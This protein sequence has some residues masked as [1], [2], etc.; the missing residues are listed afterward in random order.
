M[1]ERITTSNRN[2]ARAG[3][4]AIVSIL[5]AALGMV[6]AAYSQLHGTADFPRTRV[7]PQ[8]YSQASFQQDGSQWVR[9]HFGSSLKRPFW[10]PLVTPNGHRVTRM[11]NPQAPQGE[12]HHYSV[13]LAHQNVAGTSFWEDDG[14]SK[15]VHVSIDRFVDKT[16]CAAMTSDNEWRDGDGRVLL[17]ER[18]TT[19]VRPIDESS[20]LMQI[21]VEYLP[22]TG[23]R[24]VILGKTAYGL[25]GVR[26]TKTMDLVHG[27]GR[28]LDSEGRR[29]EA[30]IFRKPARWVDF[31][32][33]VAEDAVAG[34]ALFDH[35]D[36]PTFPT[37]FHVRDVG[38]MMPSLTLNESIEITTD[39]PLKLRYGLWVHDGLGETEAIEAAWKRFT[40]PTED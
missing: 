13:W 18:R 16:G 12:R 28:I 36:N 33:R 26:V 10:Y 22:A 27:R 34:I 2:A 6:N 29:N 37:P 7:V 21:D 35:P 40:Q 4:Q 30:R 24:S 19:T 5:L 25:L 31:S 32:G 8:P 3:V 20:W 1:K 23:E 9:Y 38:F 14:P 11:G 15:V 17:R 39:K